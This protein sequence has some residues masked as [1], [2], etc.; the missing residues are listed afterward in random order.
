MMSVYLVTAGNK[1]GTTFNKR[2]ALRAAK[3]E[4]G[5][6]YRMSRSLYRDGL[7]PYGWD[8][9]TFIMQAERIH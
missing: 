4:G 2:V 6:V 9:P 7:S 5:K 3:K 8:R 1:C